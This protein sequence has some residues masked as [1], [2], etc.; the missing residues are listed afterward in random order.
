MQMVPLTEAEMQSIYMTHMGHDFPPAELKP[1]K[2]IKQMLDLEQYTAYGLKDG[3]EIKAY[4]FFVKEATAGGIWLL[5]YYAVCQPYRSHG[6]GSLFLQRMR[7]ELADCGG[8]LLE[9]ERIRSAEN[10]EDYGIRSRRIAFYQKNGC[11]FTGLEACVW[12]VDYTILYLP[13]IR[14]DEETEMENR[15][16]M[17]KMEPQNGIVIRERLELL[18]HIMFSPEIYAR[19][20]RVWE[21]GENQCLLPDFI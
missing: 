8:I 13:M 3:K 1:W 2:N 7:R 11:L 20:V 16:D 6:Y 12:D 10:E 9:S 19:K 14:T 15:P 17:G 21:G 18:Y 4:A 5:D